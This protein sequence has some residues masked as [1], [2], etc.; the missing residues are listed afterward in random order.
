MLPAIFEGASRLSEDIIISIFMAAY[1]GVSQPTHVGVNVEDD[2]LPR[3]WQGDT[4]DEKDEEE[5]V[6][7]H[8]RE[9]GHLQQP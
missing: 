6:G 1:L 8:R 2:P 5:D 9:P 4:P 3:T 7:H